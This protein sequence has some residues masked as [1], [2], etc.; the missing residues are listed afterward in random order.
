MSASGASASRPLL[1][2]IGP[3]GAGKSVVGTLTAR[4]LGVPFIDTDRRIVQQHGPIPAIFADRGEQ[5]FRVLE[6]VE[7]QKA[8]TEH[9][10]VALGGGAVLHPDTRDDLSNTRVALIAVSADAV[11][12]RIRGT[13]RPLLADG[14][15]SWQRIM[16]DRREVYERLATLTVD[17]SQRSAASIAHEF[18]EWVQ[19]EEKE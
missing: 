11:T 18:A 15:D 10:V 16:N 7:V 8:L 4:L 14:I 19:Q 1:V 3:P 2:V 9:A 12:Q 5:G 13:G 17:S 6:R